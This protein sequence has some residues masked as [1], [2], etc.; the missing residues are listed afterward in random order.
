MHPFSTVSLSSSPRSGSKLAASSFL[1]RLSS[2]P[3]RFFH[4]CST[5]LWKLNLTMISASVLHV[6]HL[7][8]ELSCPSAIETSFTIVNFCS[9]HIPV[10]SRP[11]H[12]RQCYWNAAGIRSHSQSFTLDLRMIPRNLGPASLPLEC[13]WT[14]S[15]TPHASGLP[16]ERHRVQLSPWGCAF[17]LCDMPLSPLQC[18]IS[19]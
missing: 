5:F 17:P 10:G 1:C 15:G 2:S 12:S 6:T 7:L 14:A 9:L 8:E 11:Y 19:F 16:L 13:H 3:S 18:H 4:C